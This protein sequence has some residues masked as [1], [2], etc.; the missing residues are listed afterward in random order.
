MSTDPLGL[1][2]EQRTLSDRTRAH[3][4]EGYSVQMADMFARSADIFMSQA[5]I[6]RERACSYCRRYGHAEIKCP[7]VIDAEWSEAARRKDEP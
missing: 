4:A 3:V 1:T 7:D 6:S 5:F 2:P